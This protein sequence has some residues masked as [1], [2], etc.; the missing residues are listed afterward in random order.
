MMAAVRADG[1]GRKLA[2]VRAVWY[3]AF[4]ATPVTGELPDPVPAPHG[5]VVRVQAS[6]VCRS[7]WHGW[8]GHDP[9]I[10]AFPH[11]PGHGLAGVVEA[12]GADVR[13]WR[14]GDRVTVPFVCACGTCE[15]CAAGEY[16]VC[17]RQRQ[18]GFTH[19]GSFAELVALDWADVN[20][21]RLPEAVDSVAAAALGCRFATA[22]RAVVQVGRVRPGEWVAVHGC[23]GVGLSAVLIPGG[24]GARVVALD[25][26]PAAVEQARAAGAAV[27]APAGTD[28]RELTGGG[29]HLSVDA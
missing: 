23:G 6:G 12:V 16:Q 5:A 11:V 14:P 1:P 21:V 24:A 7:D 20:L 27:A 10:R 28:V 17:D 26:A 19:W 25:G 4:G 18:P 3:E 2:A 15:Q 9:D 29:A 13:G 22:Y 8:L